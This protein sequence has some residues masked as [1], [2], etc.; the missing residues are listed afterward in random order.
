MEAL[1]LR[2][3]RKKLN[4]PRFF[5]TAI[6]AFRYPKERFKEYTYSMISDKEIISDLKNI[7]RKI[8][9]TFNKREKISIPKLAVFDEEAYNTFSKLPLAAYDGKTETIIV[10]LKA[11]YFSAEEFVIVHEMCHHVVHKLKNSD[12]SGFT[13]MHNNYV[14][15]CKLDE[16]F[17]NFLTEQVCGRR[18]NIAYV[19]PTFIAREISNIIGLEATNRLY[20]SSAVSIIRN[21]FNQKLVAYYPNQK[22]RLI[23]HKKGIIE[24]TPF[25]VFCGNIEYVCNFWNSKS[26]STLSILRKALMCVIEMMNYY[27]YLTN[28]T[29]YRKY[30]GEQERFF[31]EY[32]S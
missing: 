9:Q 14:F 26:K 27:A 23:N 32:F 5:F 13:Y 25:E 7:L 17:N 3:G 24:V 16:G 2:K 6:M 11:E 31:K 30:R 22:L 21:D 12:M 15:G 8:M 20:L 18:K 19:F 4:K 29:N 1:L 10:N 28:T